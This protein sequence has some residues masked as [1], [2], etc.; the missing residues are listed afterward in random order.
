MRQQVLNLVNKYVDQQELAAA[1]KRMRRQI[2][3]ATRGAPLTAE[4]DS[5]AQALL[6]E[7]SEQLYAAQTEILKRSYRQLAKVTHPDMGGDPEVFHAVNTAYRLR[8]LK[9]LYNLY[10]TLVQQRNLRWVCGPDALKWVSTEQK[11]SAVNLVRMRATPEFA[12]VQSHHSGNIERANVLAQAYIATLYARLQAEYHH[13]ISKG[14]YDG[15]R[16]A[17]EGQD[18]GEVRGQ[19]TEEGGQGC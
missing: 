3:L 17:E 12:I 11:R 7:D 10:V 19:E 16:E 5:V 6:L 18:H 14:A 9:A 2:R 15:Q 8:D 4:A 1:C 13:I